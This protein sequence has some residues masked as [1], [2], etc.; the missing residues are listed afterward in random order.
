MSVDTALVRATT[1]A[2]TITAA[3]WADAE[4]LVIAGKTYTAKTTLTNTDGFVHIGTT[5]DITLA[6]LADAINVGSGITEAGTGSGVGYAAAT[7]RNPG[8][9]AVASAGRIDLY[10]LIPGTIGNVIPFTAGTS[11]VSPDAAA[12]AGGTGNVGDFFDSLLAGNQLNS[13]VFSHLRPF[14][15]VVD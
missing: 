5:I 4:T 11:D 1:F 6:N 13:E 12:L 10:A 3:D 2:A 8:V 9:Y 15:A 14:T 7:T